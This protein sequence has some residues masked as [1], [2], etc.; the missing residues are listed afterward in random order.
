MPKNTRGL[1]H[2]Q[3]LFVAQYLIDGNAT[4][5]AIAAGYS[6]KSAAQSGCELL[7]LPKIVAA[8]EAAK[9]KRL[10]R[11]DI[12]A[13]RVLQELAAMAFVPTGNM[14]DRMKASD[15]RGALVALGNHLKLFEGDGIGSKPVTIIIQ[16]SD[17]GLL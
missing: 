8:L 16:G 9:T 12:T 17:K 5:S 10:D 15:K 11:L 4:R 14:P 13:D 1:S 3:E 2:R 7:K 6:H